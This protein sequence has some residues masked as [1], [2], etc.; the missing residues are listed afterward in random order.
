MSK[1]DASDFLYVDEYL[2]KDIELILS[3]I[4][5][6][7][8]KII[9][10]TKKLPNNENAI[11]DEFIADNYLESNIVKKEFGVKEFQF[12]RETLTETGRADI[13]VFNMPKRMDFDVPPYYY[14][15]CKRIDG[16][17]LNHAKNLNT[18]YKKEGIDRYV[19]EKY[20]TYN[21]TNAMIGFIVDTIDINKNATAELG[22]IHYIFITNFKYSYQTKH[23]TNVSMQDITLYHL[24]LDFTPSI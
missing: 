22:L 4:Y 5:G 21:S 10:T 1:V 18:E 12:D 19:T 23:I 6:C 3:A 11:R 15:E 16:K 9:S 24:M 20:P 7:Y 14:I 2:D 17:N 8:L 13:R